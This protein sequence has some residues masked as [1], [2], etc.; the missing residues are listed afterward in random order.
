MNFKCIFL[1]ECFVIWTKC[2]DACIFLLQPR[3][4][5]GLYHSLSS[6]SHRTPVLAHTI[7]MEERLL[8]I[9]MP[10]Y[11][12]KENEGLNNSISKAMLWNE[13][14]NFHFEMTQNYF[15][16]L[17]SKNNQ[18]HWRFPNINCFL[19]TCKPEVPQRKCSCRGGVG[20]ERNEAPTL[21]VLF[22]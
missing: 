3:L 19:A 14:C 16:I 9:E 8:N 1:L 22:L 11:A 21:G 4:P 15:L 5:A 2:L 20:K 10:S 18:C 12:L 7:N 13:K 17:I 6:Y